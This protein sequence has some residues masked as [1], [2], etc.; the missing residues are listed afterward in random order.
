LRVRYACPSV[1]DLFPCMYVCKD[2]AAPAHAR[3]RAHIWTV[4]IIYEF[5]Q[6]VGPTRALAFVKIFYIH[7]YYNN[8]NKKKQKNACLYYLGCF[9]AYTYTYTY[10]ALFC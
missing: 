6:H 9:V 1:G 2:S 10:I 4:I 8:N 5:N 7:Y 3:T